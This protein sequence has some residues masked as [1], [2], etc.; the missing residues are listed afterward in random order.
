MIQPARCAT[1]FN[2]QGDTGGQAGSQAKEK[3]EAEAVAEAED[4]GVRD[5][6]RKQAQR[7]VL[8]TQ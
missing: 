4:N 5:R 6:S 7:T 2:R 1:K 8:S 3:T